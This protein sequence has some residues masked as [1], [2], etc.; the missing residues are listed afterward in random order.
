[1]I[2]AKA[3]AEGAVIWYIQQAVTARATRF[4]YGIQVFPAYDASD[5]RHKGRPTKWFSGLG[6]QVTGVWHQIT[7]KVCAQTMVDSNVC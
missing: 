3:V 5:P 1:M 7:P 6:N 2:R 4:A